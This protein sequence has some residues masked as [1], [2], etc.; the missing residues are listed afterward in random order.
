VATEVKDDPS[1]D[2]YSVNGT[3]TGREA[4]NPASHMMMTKNILNIDIIRYTNKFEIV[5]R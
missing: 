5:I 4:Y 1:E 3:G 2:L